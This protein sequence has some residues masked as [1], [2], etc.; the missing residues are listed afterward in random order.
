MIHYPFALCL[1]GRFL[2]MLPQLIYTPWRKVSVE[3][4]SADLKLGNN[5]GYE[6]IV[7]SILDHSL[8]RANFILSHAWWTTCPYM[9]DHI[10]RYGRYD[11]DMN[12]YPQISEPNLVPISA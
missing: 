7:F 8:R 10:R 12:E 5:V 2:F 4:C 1:R 9:R 6:R 11:V 3:G